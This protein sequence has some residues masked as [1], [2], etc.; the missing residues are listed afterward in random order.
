MRSSRQTI[1]WSAT[2]SIGRYPPVPGVA[3]SSTPLLLA[4]LSVC[5]PWFV[6]LKALVFCQGL[7]FRLLMSARPSLHAPT[8][9][10]SSRAR[11]SKLRERGDPW[12]DRGIIFSNS[13]T[14]KLQRHAESLEWIKCL[15][16]V[17][18]CACRE[19]AWT[20]V[21]SVTMPL[22]QYT[23]SHPKCPKECLYFWLFHETIQKRT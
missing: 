5:V 16:C 19:A 12:V 18:G 7:S 1:P 10:M 4:S 3:C 13:D 23:L 20:E 6:P 2:R 11:E 17:T 21:N 22:K 8:P 9:V 15:A 14:W